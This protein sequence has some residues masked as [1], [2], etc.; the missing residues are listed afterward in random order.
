MWSLSER[1]P[2]LN[3]NIHTSLYLWPCLLMILFCA[4]TESRDT[5]AEMTGEA[6][7]REMVGEGV[8]LKS[9]V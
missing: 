8:E 7:G 1:C 3:V 9:A 5:R 4:T 6:K 2:E